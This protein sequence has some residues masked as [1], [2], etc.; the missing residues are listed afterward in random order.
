MKHSK[1]RESLTEYIDYLVRR[2]GGLRL[3]ASHYRAM[4]MHAEIFKVEVESVAHELLSS[5]IHGLVN[6]S[7]F[8][9]VKRATNALVD[10]LNKFQASHEKEVDA[11][12]APYKAYH[13]A[14]S[15][16]QTF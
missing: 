1:K 9:D 5:Y 14:R 8:E 13:E 10:A 6:D 4:A 7:S 16:T 3:E 2:E 11:Y 12:L 15:K